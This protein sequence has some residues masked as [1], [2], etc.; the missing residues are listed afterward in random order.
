MSSLSDLKKKCKE[1]GVKSTGTKKVLTQRIKVSE[2]HEKLA[3]SGKKPIV[4]KQMDHGHSEQII[5]FQKFYSFV[6]RD[7]RIVG[8]KDLRKNI[9]KPLTKSDMEECK[10]RHLPFLIPTILEGEIQSHRIKKVLEDESD[11]SESEI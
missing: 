7:G 1:L 6:L 8:K 4:F 3:Q 2:F 9:V 11:E 5:P 10:L